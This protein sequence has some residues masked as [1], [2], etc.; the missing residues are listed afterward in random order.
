MA[1][2]KN[3][4]GVNVAKTLATPPERIYHKKVSVAASTRP[5]LVDSG[6]QSPE[7][8]IEERIFRNQGNGNINIAW[9]D[10]NGNGKPDLEDG[11]RVSS[12]GTVGTIADGNNQGVSKIIF[13]SPNYIV[14]DGSKPSQIRGEFAIKKNKEGMYTEINGYTASQSDFPTMHNLAFQ[15]VKKYYQTTEAKRMTYQEEPLPAN[16]F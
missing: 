11:Y 8:P 10:T 15:Y 2:W 16:K 9:Q 4:P 14:I 12:R 1:E 3:L 7:L 13:H 6:L 5:L